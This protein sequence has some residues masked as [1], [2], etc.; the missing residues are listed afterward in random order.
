MY[1]R[2]TTHVWNSEFITSSLWRLNHTRVQL[3]C[4]R[5]PTI[6]IEHNLPFHMSVV[7]LLSFIT[8]IWQRWKW[9]PFFQNSLIQS[10]FTNIPFSLMSVTLCAFIHGLVLTSNKNVIH[11]GPGWFECGMRGCITSYRA[12]SYP[13]VVKWMI[14]CDNTKTSSQ[15][16]EFF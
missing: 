13:G 8:C 2:K 15:L 14:K 11:G 5:R 12:V 4:D 9:T 10:T 1:N 6:E 3:E 16:Q 7:L